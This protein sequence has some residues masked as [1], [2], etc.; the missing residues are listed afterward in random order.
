MV[1]DTPIKAENSKEFVIS[2]VDVWG[3]VCKCMHMWPSHLGRIYEEE[4]LGFLW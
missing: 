4:G 2:G 3:H 1:N